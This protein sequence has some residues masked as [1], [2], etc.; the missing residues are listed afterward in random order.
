M[1]LKFLPVVKCNNAMLAYASRCK[2]SFDYFHPDI[3]MHI[4]CLETWLPFMRGLRINPESDT[5]ACMTVGLF[6]AYMKMMTEGYD[7]LLHFDADTIIT[8]RLDEML[9]EDYDIAVCTC[10]SPPLYDAGVW[11]S[12]DIQFIKDFYQTNSAGYSIDVYTFELV[13]NSYRHK[14][15]KMVDGVGS[16]VL[17]S[18]RSREW[19]NRLEIRDDRIYTPDR[20]I[21]V[22]HWAG[23]F[24]TDIDRFSCSYFS[25]DVKLWLNKITSGTTFTDNDGTEFGEWLANI[26]GWNK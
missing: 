24:P 7:T 19:W 11:A 16:G 9:A 17:Y 3:P 21:K 26:Y 4:V 2:S 15:V 25:N 18:E 22:M 14:N 20:Q 23:G 13:V 5:K 6:Y 8:G 12:R 10:A 1:V